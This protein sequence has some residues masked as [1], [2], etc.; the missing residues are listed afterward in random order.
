VSLEEALQR[1]E[2][3][4][5]AL[6]REGLAYFLNR[7]V[8]VRP[9][10]G[11]NPLLMSIDPLRSAI[12][13]QGLR[14]GIALLALARPPSA[15]AGRAHAEALTRRPVRHPASHGRQGPDSKIKR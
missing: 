7:S 11:E 13:A 2:P 8:M 3:E 6:D 4:A 10:R 9:E 12:T 5:K 14:P 15:D 1:A